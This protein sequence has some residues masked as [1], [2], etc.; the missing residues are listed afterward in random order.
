MEFAD[1]GDLY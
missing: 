1:G